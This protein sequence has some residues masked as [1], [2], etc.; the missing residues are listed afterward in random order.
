M[1]VEGGTSTSYSYDCMNRLT[2]ATGMGFDW[3]KNGNMVYMH[4][5]SDAWNYTYDPE[6]RLISVKKNDALMNKFW[7]DAEGRRVRLWDSQDGYL[8]HVYSGLDIIYETSQSGVTKHYYANGLHV[9]ENRSGTLEYFHQDHLGSTRLK[10][11]ANGDAVFTRN[12]EPFGPDY[13]GSGSEEFKY[14]GKHEDPS[15]LYYFGAR[16][17]LETGKFI[18]EDP[19]IG[20]LE[21]PQN[22]QLRL[23][24]EH[25]RKPWEHQQQVFQQ[26]IPL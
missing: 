4:D 21:D 26:K 25:L 10:T 9:A 8:T 18:T 16:Y 15:G 1:D 7:Y 19:I 24:Q 20:S 3:D 14:T 2:S 17:F 13:D 22:L 5:G 23:L 12:Y 6:N 11:D